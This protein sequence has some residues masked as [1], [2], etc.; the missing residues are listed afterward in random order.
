M[1]SAFAAR[2][3]AANKLRLPTGAA[4]YATSNLDSVIQA[5]EKYGVRFLS[6]DEI[7]EQMPLYL[8]ARH[9]TAP[10]AAAVE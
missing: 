7:A 6:P 8:A 1:S 9:Q 5:F 10:G 4:T 2:S 3:S